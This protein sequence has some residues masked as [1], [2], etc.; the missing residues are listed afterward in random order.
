[1]DVLS[2][3]RILANRHLLIYPVPVNKGTRKTEWNNV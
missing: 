3:L 1:M 2:P